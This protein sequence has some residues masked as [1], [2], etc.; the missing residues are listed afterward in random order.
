MAEQALVHGEKSRRG[1]DQVPD[2]HPGQHVQGHVHYQVAVTQVMVEGNGHAIPH[3]RQSEGFL[4]GGDDFAFL[5]LL[6][7]GGNIFPFSCKREGFPV[8]GASAHNGHLSPGRHPAASA[9]ARIFS[10]LATTGA[11]IIRPS[12]AITPAPLDDAS[13]KAAITLRANPTS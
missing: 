6:P 8:A 12:R 4:E 9:R 5:P 11:S 3:F 13:R 1:E 7:D 2:A 10:A